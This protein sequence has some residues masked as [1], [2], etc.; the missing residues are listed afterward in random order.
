MRKKLISMLL[1]T[2]MAVTMLAGCGSSKEETASSDAEAKSEEAET[3]EGETKDGYRYR[4]YI[5][6]NINTFNIII[7]GKYNEEKTSVTIANGIC[8]GFA[9]SACNKCRSNFTISLLELFEY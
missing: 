3:E 4:I 5:V 6:S 8:N 7:N 2:A 1:C 9:N